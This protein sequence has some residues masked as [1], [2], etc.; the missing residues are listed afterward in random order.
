VLN[1]V[2]D[3]EFTVNNGRFNVVQG[4]DGVPNLSSANADADSQQTASV[5]PQAIHQSGH[6]PVRAILKA[7]PRVGRPEIYIRPLCTSGDVM[8]AMHELLD[9]SLF[10]CGAIVLPHALRGPFVRDSNSG[11]FYRCIYRLNQPIVTLILRLANDSWVLC[12]LIPTFCVLVFIGR[13]AQ[14]L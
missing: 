4:L 12:V 11:C 2:N 9:R 14:P 7:I 3:F 5:V 10:K 13:R 6:H 1:L 8:L